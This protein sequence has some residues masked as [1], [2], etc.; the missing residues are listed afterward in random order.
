MSP[1]SANWHAWFGH[2][3]NSR[4]LL[5]GSDTILVT[6]HAPIR[7]VLHTSAAIQYSLGLDKLRM[8]LLP[9]LNRL[10]SGIDR[11]DEDI[12]IFLQPPH[13]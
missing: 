1:Q 13:V 8:L 4:H 2:I 6:D 7:E 12:S 9:F 11:L 3:Q 10:Q 5:E